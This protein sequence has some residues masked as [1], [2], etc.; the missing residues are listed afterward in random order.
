MHPKSRAS[1]AD[2]NEWLAYVRRELP[3][4]EQ[5]SALAYGRTELFLRFLEL[6]GQSL[7]AE[8]EAELERILG[9]S[10][11]DRAGQ[12]DA[13]NERI[14]AHLIEMLFAEAGSTP[15]HERHTSQLSP[16]Q[17][18][19]ELLDHLASRNPYFRL[20]IDYKRHADCSFNER[21]WGE[22]LRR[23]LGENDADSL[24][25]AKAMAELDRLLVWLHDNNIPLPKYFFER[26]WFLHFLHEPERMAQTRSL[27]STLAAEIPPCMSA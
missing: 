20:W 17:Q 21:A 11:P 26:T 10:D 25:F 19:Q 24:D 6:R 2:H 13:L 23:Q 27:L 8:V 18:T 15:G 12:L 1:F 5:P 22:Y 4:D 14:M 16:R 7:S 9:L 3:R